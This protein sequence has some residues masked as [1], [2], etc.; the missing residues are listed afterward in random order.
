MS[1]ATIHAN[2]AEPQ[3]PADEGEGSTNMV[4][5]NALAAFMFAIVLCS[6]VPYLTLP[7]LSLPELN[8]PE[9]DGADC[10]TAADVLE[11]QARSRHGIAPTCTDA[12][13]AR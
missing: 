9:L 7:D 11:H 1:T 5:A 3:T 4:I 13:L 10:L 2:T 6:S 8:V 12:M